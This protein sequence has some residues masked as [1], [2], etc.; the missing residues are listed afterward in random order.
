MKKEK[1]L[2]E[3]SA[4]TAKAVETARIVPDR[5]EPAQ[6]ADIYNPWGKGDARCRFGRDLWV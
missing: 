5:R 4:N 3:D 6:V 2:P 1:M